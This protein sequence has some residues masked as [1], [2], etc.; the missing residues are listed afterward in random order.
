[1]NIV[2][3]LQHLKLREGNLFLDITQTS[4][5]YPIFYQWAFFIALCL[6]VFEGIKRKVPLGAWLVFSSFTTV[7]I[8]IGSKLGAYRIDEIHTFFAQGYL[9]PQNGKNAIGAALFA[10]L[11]LWVLKK[12]IGFKG[13]VWS[14]F[15]YFLP[16]IMLIQRMGCLAAG[17]CYGKPTAGAGV[18]YFGPSK[19]RD[20]QIHAEL[21]T[22]QQDFTA[23][24]H[25]TPIY[26]MLVAL[27]TLLLLFVVRRKV[28]SVSLVYISLGMM[29]LGRFIVDFF[30]DPLSHPNLANEIWGVKTLQW[31]ALVLFITMIA[32]II[33]TEKKP[34]PT[35]TT[36]EID[37]K[38]NNLALWVLSLIIYLVQDF[39]T[40]EEKWVLWL[41][42]SAA[43]LFNIRYIWLQTKKLQPTLLTTLWV[44]SAFTLVAQVQPY[45]K[46]FNRAS[47]PMDSTYAYR[48]YLKTG[49][50]NLILPVTY[51]PCKT[52]DYTGGGCSTP[53]EPYCAERLLSDP[54]GPQYQLLYLG[55][56]QQY[57][58]FSSEYTWFCGVDVFRELFTNKE[59]EH[60]KRLTTLHM[61]SGFEYNNAFGGKIGLRLGQNFDP[62]IIEK[63]QLHSSV[64]WSI[65]TWLGSKRY[66]YVEMGINDENTFMPTHIGSI[67]Y[68][69]N[70]SFWRDIEVFK[71]MSIGFTS[72]SNLQYYNPY[73]QLHIGYLEGFFELENK[74]QIRP[75]IG[76]TE[77]VN[78]SISTERHLFFGIKGNFELGRT[79]KVK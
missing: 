73:N 70:F 26:Y 52:L 30:R 68:Q 6:F 66:F 61:Y 54:Y 78:P 20:L 11:G 51:F 12:S 29:S 28:Q 59:F 31:G 18:Q 23:Q 45:D 71:R 58:D 65:R 75:S 4:A 72:F 24:I 38:K 62:D 7:F 53:A 76:I 35:P 74:L 60:V 22:R 67:N 34:K 57:R 17:C 50:S 43:G 15:A 10:A 42:L 21:I 32:L 46:Y 41:Q 27:L 40:P 69:F 33:Y 25:A 8:V 39:F 19:L 1:M 56:E 48:T 55:L 79:T 3:F 63:Q 37:P 9:P 49:H 14:A 77:Y 64:A 36:I 44:L 47:N 16:T 13:D 2:E 5:L